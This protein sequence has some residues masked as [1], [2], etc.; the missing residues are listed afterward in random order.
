[1]ISYITSNSPYLRVDVF[2]NTPYIPPGQTSAGLVRWNSV[3][4]CLEIY[5]GS[6]W[7]RMNGSVSIDVTPD[8]QEVFEW[9]RVQMQREREYQRLAESHVSVQDSLNKLKEAEQQLRVMVDLVKE[10]NGG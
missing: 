4:N 2:S 7:V 3:N 10:H 8:F 5:D 9:A 1:M 6:S